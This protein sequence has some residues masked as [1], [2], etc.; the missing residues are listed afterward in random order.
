M[1]LIFGIINTN[2]QSANEQSLADLYAGIQHFPH[3]RKAF[4]VKD[5]AA[6][7][8]ALTYN[9]PE[10][11]F[12][13]QPIEEP[14]AQLLFVAEGRIDNREELAKKLN[15]RLHSQ[16]PDGELMLRAYQKWGKEAVHQLLGDW[17]FAAYD[18]QNQELF[19]ARDHHGYTALFYH[20]DGQRLVFSSSIKAL[21][22]LD[23]VAQKPNVAHI[24]RGLAL[25]GDK[26]NQ[27]IFENI[28]LLP[29][30]HTLSLKNGQIDVKRYW[31]PENI[32][33]VYYK[34]HQDYA[35]EL[36]EI[37]TDAV[38]V[39]LR[40]HKPVAS[41]L[42]GGLDSGSVAFLAA[43]LLAE[44]NVPLPT[45]SHVPLFKE[46]LKTHK[47]THQFFDETPYILATAEAAGN[48]QAQLLNSAQLSVS[49]GMERIVEIHDSV[50]HAACNAY[51]LIDINQKAKQQGFGALLSGEMGNASISYTG[52]DYLQP[53][54]HPMFLQN[55]KRLIKNR[56]LKPI[57]LKYL[58]GW[59]N[60]R[61]NAGIEN[62][63]KT[64]YIKPSVVADWQIL[65]DIRQNNLGFMPYLTDAKS[66]MLQILM[67][68]SN[69]RCMFG[70][71]TKHYYGLEKR[72]PTGDRRVVE[73]CLG[74]PNAAFF[75][76][77]GTPKQVLRNM[78]H[79]RLPNKVLYERKKGLQSADVNYRILADQQAIS[80]L[81]AQTCPNRTFNEIIDTQKIQND[82]KAFLQNPTS[83]Q[84][85][86]SGLLKSLMVGQFLEKHSF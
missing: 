48:I 34:N 69:P 61:K 29:P 71:N 86:T 9:T 68:G 58:S 38:R 54:H 2:Q 3:E 20:F 7:G 17:S 75:G 70:A 49:H 42:S 45:L 40:S 1:S 35:E 23:S 28:F 53:W 73:Y 63:I 21:L 27:T 57:A 84:I 64:G 59:V 51:W 41:M 60:N 47:E 66:G 83:D 5:N 78:M 85:D 37:L 11:L 33:P 77:D 12:E 44:Q 36:R 24:L 43:R 18:V 74:I 8:H 31:F 26:G 30:A 46:E 39:R 65:E 81:I 50:I 72:D 76:Q 15:I 79:H 56:L 82:W 32:A 10:A 19:M 25:W 16:L 13:Q 6:F 22:A 14:A 4:L 62:Y 80:Q 55:P 67:V 52:L